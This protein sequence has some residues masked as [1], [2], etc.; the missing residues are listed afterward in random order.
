MAKKK[1]KR[2]AAPASSPTTKRRR[3]SSGTKR[4]SSSRRRGGGRAGLTSGWDKTDL[5]IALATAAGVGYLQA[6]VAK[7]D[8]KP[9]EMK[10]YKEM[11]VITPVG[12]VGTAAI[13]A[14]GVAHFGKVRRAKGVA[15]GLAIASVF[16]LGRRE[17]SL[18]T[19][20]EIKTNL[21]GFDEASLGGLDDYLALGGEVDV[22]YEDYP[23]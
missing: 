21:A 20:E 16:S 5:A 4:R 2:R 15:L 18:Y 10:W 22:E 1:R 23:G 14:G 12:R 13:V 3:S 11:P 8:D 6:K 9:D 19:D 17:F 7:T